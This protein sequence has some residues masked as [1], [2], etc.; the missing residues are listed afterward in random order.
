M[1]AD[2]KEGS[3]TFKKGSAFYI[4]A[5]Q[6]QYRMVSTFFEPVKTFYDSVFYDASAWTV[7]L[8]FDMPYQSTNKAV[9]L[10]TALSIKNLQPSKSIIP[11][12]NY[13]YLM[14]W[15]DY[16]ACLLYTSPSPRDRG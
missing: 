3:T 10:G 14:E 2:I 16:N 7:A 13:A 5:E 6:A 1:N 12:A 4:P 11:D 9:S 15:N 8:A